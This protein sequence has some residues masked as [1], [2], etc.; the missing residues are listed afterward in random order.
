MYLA[1]PAS[2]NMSAQGENGSARPPGSGGGGGNG[3]AF[4]LPDGHNLT[5]E[6]AAFLQRHLPNNSSDQPLS[7]EDEEAP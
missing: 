5:S 7:D 1:V 6:E 4:Y 3:G 2:M